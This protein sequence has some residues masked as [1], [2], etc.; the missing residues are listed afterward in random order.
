MALLNLPPEQL[1]AAIAPMMGA[2]AARD[3]GTPDSALANVADQRKFYEETFGQISTAR[4]EGFPGRLKADETLGTRITEARS[5]QYVVVN[6]LLTQLARVTSREAASLARL[7]LA[8]AALALEGFRAEQN[9]YPDAP[10]SS[11]RTYRGPVDCLMAKY[12]V[13]QDTRRPP[14]P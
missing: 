2:N 1:R 3:S 13:S 6:A 5:S 10:M 12:P 11:P 8:Q 14:D 9:R 7:R 4:N